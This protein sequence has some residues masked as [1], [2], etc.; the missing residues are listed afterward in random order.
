MEKMDKIN[1][2]MEWLEKNNID[3]EYFDT[4]CNMDKP[5]EPLLTANWNEVSHKM[6]DY[7]ETVI[8]THWNDEVSRCDCCYGAILTTPL[9]Y[10]DL[11][12]YVIF[13]SEILCKNCILEDESIQYDIIDYY[14]NKTDKA[15]MPWFFD[16]IEKNGFVC[17]SPDEY[18]QIFETGF[19]RGQNDNPVDIAND[20]KKNLPDYDYI[21]KINSAGQF[22]IHWSVFIRKNN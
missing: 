6:T 11:P 16:I 1:R 12:D 21:F 5:E 18:C 8:D 17:Y 13:D 2:I 14:I 3:Y 22:D 15:I 20:I 9:Y 19:H 4:K 10:G 7:I